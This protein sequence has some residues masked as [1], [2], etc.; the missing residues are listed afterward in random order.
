MLCYRS[1]S[2]SSEDA[3]Y[4]T[5]WKKLSQTFSYHKAKPWCLASDLIDLDSKDWDKPFPGDRR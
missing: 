4:V 3:V 1:L 5:H 2:L